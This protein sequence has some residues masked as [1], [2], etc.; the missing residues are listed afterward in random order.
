MGAWGAFLMNAMVAAGSYPWT[1]IAL[2]RRPDY[3]GCLEAASVNHDIEPFARASLLTK[4]AR[5]SR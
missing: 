3:M 1:I 4:A 2:E 5:E